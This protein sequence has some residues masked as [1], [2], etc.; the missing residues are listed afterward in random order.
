MAAVIAFDDEDEVLAMAND[1]S[2]GLAAYVYTRNLSRAVRTFRA[3]S[4][5]S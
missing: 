1:T 5:V 3:C 2:Y 4:S